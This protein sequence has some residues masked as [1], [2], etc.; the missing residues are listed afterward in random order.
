MDRAVGA[1]PAERAWGNQFIFVPTLEELVI[2]FET[3][4]RKK[5]QLDAILQR[6]LQW[7]FPMQPDKSLYLVA[8]PRS[9]NAYTWVGAKE[10]D[11]KSQ[12]RVAPRPVVTEAGS[13]FQSV[14]EPEPKPVPAIPTLKPF[15]PLS[16]S[17]GSHPEF[18]SITEEEFYVVFLTWKK[19]RVDE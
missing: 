11:L 8:E 12:R 10:V 19:Q 7:K 4:M 14:Q 5:D 18:D 3:I 9:K 1:R 16:A 15:D 17:S 13:E 2:E 6:A